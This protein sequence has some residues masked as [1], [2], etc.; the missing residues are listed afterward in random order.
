MVGLR[1]RLLR[2]L[3]VLAIA[4]S[5]GVSVAPPGLASAPTAGVTLTLG[6]DGTVTAA[7]ETV[8]SNGSALRFAMDGNFSPLVDS[9]P[10]TNASRA[11]LLLTISLLEA[12]PLDAGF[13]GDHDGRV[14][15]VVD[16][17]HFQNFINYAAHLVPLSSFTGIL[18]VTLD[19][20]T[21]TAENLQAI[22]FSNAVAADTSVASIG[23]TAT[24]VA[25]F[26]WS[27]TTNAHTFELAWNLP[28]ALGNL[29]VPVEALN[30]SFTTPAGVSITS[31]T[32]LSGTRI[33]NDPSGWGSASASGQYT[34]LPG[35]NVVVQFGPAFP[36][37]TVAVITSVSGA[38]VAAVGLLLLRRRRRQRHTIVALPPGATSSP[39]SGVGP[40]SGSE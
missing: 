4:V 3:G 13:F 2:L 22:S 20:R 12:N 27:G 17:P 38:A 36:T 31:A 24:T 30:L 26:A 1:G 6:G 16:V 21:P 32:G 9:L 14:D 11:S 19:A 10:G 28:S 18:N 39:E 23:V 15:A 29:S 7:L 33:T 37:G 5:V 35:H 25:N 40:S 34:P 8:V